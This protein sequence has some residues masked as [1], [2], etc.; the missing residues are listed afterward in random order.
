MNGTAVQIKT[1]RTG[2]WIELAS[3]LDALFVVEEVPSPHSPDKV[4]V[5]RFRGKAS[6]EFADVP[7]EEIVQHVNS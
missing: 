5:R 7:G 6:F 1:C 2:D 4:Q 3:E